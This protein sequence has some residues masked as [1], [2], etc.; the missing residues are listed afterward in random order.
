MVGIEII[1]SC[2]D[3][4]NQKDVLRI[5][6]GTEVETALF[7]HRGAVH[8][9]IPTQ[10]G[11]KMGCRHCSTTYAPIPYVRDLSSAEMNEIIAV[12]REQLWDTPLPLV[13]S[14]SGHGEPMMNWDNV[15]RCACGCGQMFSSIYVTSIG[16][17]DTMERILASPEYHPSVYFSIHGSSDAERARL[18]PSAGG[19]NAASLRQIIDFGRAYTRQGER[20]VWN[21][22]IC[23]TNSSESSLQQLLE[24][25]AGIEYP[26][27]L[28]FTKYIDIH[29]R[30]RIAEIGD[31]S[32]RAFYQKM[33][34]QVRP[35][36]HIRLSQLEGE[37]MGIAC[38]QMRASVRSHQAAAGVR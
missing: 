15:R 14:F 37:S 7:E 17:L 5:E 38:G 6:E 33:S 8:F 22:M 3:D 21:Y 31:A 28:R 20:V 11:C 18:I 2:R 36:I 27:E 12:M 34:E 9:C 19:R 25:C 4:K 1:N 16:I 35:N 30:N 29:K 24:L 32:F 23:S 13:L 10:A 26:L